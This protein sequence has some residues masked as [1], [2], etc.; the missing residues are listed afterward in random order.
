M[1]ENFRSRL[2]VEELNQKSNKNSNLI[3]IKKS[4]PKRNRTKNSIGSFF[5][6]SIEPDVVY[7]QNGGNEFT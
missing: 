1:Q 7:L 2:L 3:E 5:G 6:S 4:L